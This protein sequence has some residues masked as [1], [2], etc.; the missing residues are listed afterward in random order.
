[1]DFSLDSCKYRL[2]QIDKTG[3]IFKNIALRIHLLQ[4]RNI[5]ILDIV[6]T[7]YS[8]CHFFYHFVE[9]RPQNKVLNLSF[10]K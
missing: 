7:S 1:M 9:H 8:L 3:L 5:S 2:S 6:S 10:K 4:A